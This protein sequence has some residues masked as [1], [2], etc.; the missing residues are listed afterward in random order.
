MERIIFRLKQIRLPFHGRALVLMPAYL[1]VTPTTAR[2]P[3]ATDTSRD[4]CRPFP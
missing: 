3:A 1:Q 2:F 4:K